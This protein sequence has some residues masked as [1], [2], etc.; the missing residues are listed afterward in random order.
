M[1]AIPHVFRRNATY[2]WRRRLCPC[3]QSINRIL[4]FS[5]HTRDGRLERER[6]AF[7]TATSERLLA[8]WRSELLTHDEIT[9]I[10]R[11]EADRH[12]S[13]LRENVIKA[14]FEGFDAPFDGETCDRLMAEVYSMLA[15]KGWHGNWTAEELGKLTEAGFTPKMK[16][17]MARMLVDLSRDM[18]MEGSETHLISILDRLAYRADYD[19]V[20]LGQAENAYFLTR[21]AVLKQKV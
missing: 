18:T 9:A 21:A 20:E 7:L 4:S 1:P 17:E 10:M 3:A 16:F 6:S 11:D 14:R 8:A 13:R 12:S 2:Y 19:R 5:L 15:R